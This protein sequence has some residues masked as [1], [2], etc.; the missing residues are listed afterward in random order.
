MGK[1]RKGLRD[2]VL[3]HKIDFHI[4]RRRGCWKYS[5]DRQ[6]SITQTISLLKMK[7][8][9]QMLEEMRKIYILCDVRDTQR[10]VELTIDFCLSIGIWESGVGITWAASGE[11]WIQQMMP[12][13]GKWLDNSACSGT[14]S[15]NRQYEQLWLS[16][17]VCVLYNVNL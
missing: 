13:G 16:R 12:A 9:G 15:N 3:S 4:W 17:E 2:Y 7:L 6:Y 5:Y 11:N 8:Y 1:E 14:L 10:W